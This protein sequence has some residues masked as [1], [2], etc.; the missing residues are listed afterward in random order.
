[1]LRQLV[2]V[3]A[4]CLLAVTAGVAQTK[5]VKLR[6]G[7]QLQGE[8]TRSDGKYVIQTR[9]GS[10]RIDARDVVSIT[11]YVAPKDEYKQRLAKIDP[12]SAEDHYELGK[13]ALDKGLLE[14]AR[15]ELKRAVALQSDFERASLLLRQVEARILASKG[16][17]IPAT[18]PATTAVTAGATETVVRSNVLL[19]QEDI[20]RIRL[21]EL[22]RRDFVRVEFKNDVVNRFI[23]RMSGR[24]EFKLPRAKER[25][26]ALRPVAKVAYI[27]ENTS[28]SDSGIRDDILIKTDPSA[29]A[30]FRRRIWPILS[31]S[32]GATQCHGG[33]KVN[34]GF[35]LIAARAR[36][37]RIDYTNFLLIDGVVVE[38]RR[39]IERDLVE[40]SLLLEFGLPWGQARYKHPVKLQPPPFT[41]RSN[42]NYVRILA[43]LNMLDGPQHPDYRLQW[44]PP[45]GLKLDFTG[46]VQLP[47][48]APPSTQPSEEVE[49]APAF[50]P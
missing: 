28:R 1:M 2:I 11:E 34:G 26:M 8:V 35:K 46:K 13:W 3:M 29:L 22:R 40:R 31:N 12:Q 5:L 17:Q 18:Q 43:W 21:E 25:F 32:C 41:S 50:E 7:R 45:F 20:Y 39:M 15:V 6:D 19:S 23:E 38:G 33:E 48:P 27:L 30:E 9:F 42:V 47:P 49:E 16:S 4:L 10:V 36:N 24:E 14:A 44:Q 37:E